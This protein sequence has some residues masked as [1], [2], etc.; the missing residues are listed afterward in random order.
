LMSGVPTLVFAP[1]LSAVAK[2]STDH[3]VACVVSKFNV[4][5]LCKAIDQLINDHGYREL[6][7]SNAVSRILNHHTVQITNERF[8][9][10]IV[11]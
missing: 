10:L 9:A 6:L 3:N 5:Q 2:Y 7:S 1:E 8:N 4:D 11:S